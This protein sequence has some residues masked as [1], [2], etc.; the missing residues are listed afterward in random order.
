VTRRSEEPRI[1][2]FV[3]QCKA[4]GLKITPQRL[5]V[6]RALLR[7]ETHPNPDRLYRKIKRSHPTI[8]H[9][10]VYATLESFERHGIIAR[11]TPLHETVRFDPIV[12]PHHHIVCIRCKTVTNL[13]DPDFD[14]LPIPER[15]RRDQTVLG[16]SVYI[17][18]LCPTCRRNVA[19]R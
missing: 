1:Q 10:T 15:V 16:Y 13:L 5:L 17:N 11:V 8:S 9:A 3:E 6:Y 19:R 4:A 14:A 7:D 2:K 12:E 18:V